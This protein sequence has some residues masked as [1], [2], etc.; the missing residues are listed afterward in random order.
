MSTNKFNPNI[1]PKAE[2][3]K[4]NHGLHAFL[5]LVTGM[6]WVPV[7]ITMIMVNKVRRSINESRVTVVLYEREDGSLGGESNK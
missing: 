2:Y 5:T 1:L 6:M 3:P 7:W 4:T